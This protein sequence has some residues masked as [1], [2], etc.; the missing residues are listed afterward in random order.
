MIAANIALVYTSIA[1]SFL[2][3]SL[4]LFTIAEALIT[5]LA[6]KQVISLM[7]SINMLLLRPTIPKFF[8]AK[9]ALHSLCVPIFYVLLKFWMKSVTLGAEVTFEQF[10]VL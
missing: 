4:K 9:L 7:K 10:F 6:L 3:M 8:V 1:P 2:V 5:L